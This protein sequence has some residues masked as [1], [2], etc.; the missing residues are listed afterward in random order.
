MTPSVTIL[1]LALALAA[2]WHSLA[3]ST[4]RRYTLK[5]TYNYQNFFDKFNFFES[6]YGTGNYNDV[7]PTWGYINYRNRADAEALGLIRTVGTD[8]YIGV[9]HTSVTQYPGTGRSSVRLESKQT[10][11]KGLFIARFSHLPKPVCGTWSAFWS[12]GDPWPQGGEL[13]WY[14]G[15]NDQTVNTPVLHTGRASEVGPCYLSNDG[16]TSTVTHA[17][18]DNYGGLWENHGCTTKATQADPWGS[19]D[20]GIYAV[21]WTDDYIKFFSWRHGAAPPDIA[22]DSPDPQ[23]WGT[24]SVL[25]ANSLCDINRH[26]ASQKLVLNINFCGAAGLSHIWGESCRGK[27]QEEACGNYVA[28]NPWAFKD[29]YWQIQGIRVFA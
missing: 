13:D 19:P 23:R 8:V 12:T 20:G 17:N 27:T 11:N 2:P 14:E 7:D 5:E 26:F 4:T 28:R 6:R 29:V 18:C 1:T 25:I 22:S 3:T 9:D 16:Q 21:E 10:Y 15:W 24:P